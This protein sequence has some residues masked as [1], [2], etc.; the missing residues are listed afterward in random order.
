MQREN[1]VNLKETF[2]DQARWRREK[3]KEYP[4]DARNTEA[5]E[6]FDQLAATVWQIKP[7]LIVLLESALDGPD[8]NYINN[9]R[10]SDMLSLIGFRAFYDTA[11]EFVRAFVG[12]TDDEAANNSR[13]HWSQRTTDLPEAA[14][15]F[16]PSERAATRE[17]MIREKIRP[18]HRALVRALCDFEKAIEGRED[19]R[20]NGSDMEPR[21]YESRDEKV[22]D[23]RNKLI[24]EIAALVRDEVAP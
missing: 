11:E 23:T 3:A 14:E 17:R 13:S 24:T 7:E 22:N 2:E 12:E 8:D 18:E 1:S 16:V 19:A 10:F 4:D 5:A 20:W 9:E 15:H 6:I 21:A